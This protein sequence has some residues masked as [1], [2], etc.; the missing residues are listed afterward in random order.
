MGTTLKKINSFKISI[1][2]TLIFYDDKLTGGDTM[3]LS[4]N[5]KTIFQIQKKIAK[6]L[7]FFIKHTSN[8]NNQLTNK[9]HLTSVKRGCRKYS[10]L[11]RD[12]KNELN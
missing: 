7:K 3:C 10:R 12:I 11:S 9:A 4:I 5:K 2:K 8:K 1:N 6:N